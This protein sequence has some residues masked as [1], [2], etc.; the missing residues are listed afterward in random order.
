[1]SQAITLQLP[2]ELA[3]RART[4]AAKTHRPVEDVV[5]DWLD[6]A[7]T[8]SGVEVLPEDELLKVCDEQLDDAQ[9]NELRE[10]LELNQEGAL[11]ATNRKRLD[12]LMHVYRRGWLRKAIALKTAVARGLRP[13]L[14]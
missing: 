1:M 12:E 9:Q 7:D 5:L 6:R 14:S 8:E 4:V 13:P 2:D 3:Q 10:L 11:T